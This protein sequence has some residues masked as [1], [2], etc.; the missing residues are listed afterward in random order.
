[1]GPSASSWRHGVGSCWCSTSPSWTEGSPPSR[2]SPTPSACGPSSWPCSDR[3]YLPPFRLSVFASLRLCVF[4][5]LR[6]SVFLQRQLPPPDHQ[7]H[8][9][10]EHHD[11]RELEEEPAVALDLDSEP[12]E[13]EED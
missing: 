7:H 9:G 8:C 2:R 5:S 4:P 1:M 3:R 11:E 6:L 13:V 12:G 10:A